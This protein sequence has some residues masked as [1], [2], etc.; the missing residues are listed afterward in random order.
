MIYGPKN[1]GT[2]SFD[3]RRPDPA[4]TAVVAAVPDWRI[5]FE[6]EQGELPAT[7]AFD[8]ALNFWTEFIY[9]NAICRDP[10][11]D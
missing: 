10:P 5:S 3:K 2:T 7:A 1:D 6:D 11:Q 4:V 9:Q 8:L